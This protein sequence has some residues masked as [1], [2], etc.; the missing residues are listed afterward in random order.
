MI[1]KIKAMPG[2]VW[3]GKNGCFGDV[4]IKKIVR[5]N[6]G[7]LPYNPPSQEQLNFIKGKKFR[8][9]FQLK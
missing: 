3:T 9:I 4:R 1:K 2:Q 8:D 6:I 7:F 5:G